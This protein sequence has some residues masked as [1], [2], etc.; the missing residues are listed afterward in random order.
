MREHAYASVFL[1]AESV[2]VGPVRVLLRAPA[3]RLCSV[4]EKMAGFYKTVPGSMWVSLLNLSGE[5]PLC[6][7]SVL[8]KI[9]TGVIGLFATALFGI[10][11][12]VLGAG[13][14]EVIEEVTEETPDED[15]GIMDS[16]SFLGSSHSVSSSTAERVEIFQFYAIS[17]KILSSRT[18]VR[19]SPGGRNMISSNSISEFQ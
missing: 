18:V 14:E 17:N 3:R 16:E 2:Q 6:N 12:G 4:P 9:L 1:Y 5:S 19:K 15:N 7:Y 13:L 11:I 10:P 8:G